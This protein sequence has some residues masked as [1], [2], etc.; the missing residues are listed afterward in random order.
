MRDN[1]TVTKMTAE[2]AQLVP[3]WIYEGIYSLYNHDEDFIGECMDG[4]HFA[5]TGQDG[6]LLGYFCF[7]AEA[8]I[9]AIEAG[10]YDDGFLDIGLHIKPDLCGKKLGSL[11]LGT[12]LEYAASEYC[13]TRFRATI[14]DFNKRSQALFINLGFHKEKEVTHAATNGKFVVVKRG[15]QPSL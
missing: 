15:E 11:F 8:R 6:E 14:A 1:I 10:A 5:F 13:T 4:N 12:C 2:Y 9:P 7:G 3:T